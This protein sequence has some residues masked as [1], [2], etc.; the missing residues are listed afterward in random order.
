MEAPFFVS[1]FAT[2]CSVR[3]HL[4]SLI[5][6]RSTFSRSMLTSICSLLVSTD[7]DV[8]TA[9]RRDLLSES[10]ETMME[11]VGKQSNSSSLDLRS[12]HVSAASTACI[13]SAAREELTIRFTRLLCHAMGANTPFASTMNRI[14][15]P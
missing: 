12:I 10:K 7:V 3:T 9:S 11:S 8:W 15:P 13:H 1:G 14:K 5:S 2:W 4:S 6:L